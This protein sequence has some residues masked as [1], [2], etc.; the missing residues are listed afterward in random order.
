MQ[1]R[2]ITIIGTSHIAKSSIEQVKTT[3]EVQKPDIVAIELDKGRAHSLMS[4]ERSSVSWH[5]ISRIGLKGYL[6]AKLGHWVEHKLGKVVGVAPGSE[7]K[8]AILS[9]RMAK[10]QLALIDQPIQRT[11][12]RFSKAFSWREKLQLIWDIL[13][14]PFKKK[15][16]RFD[17]RKVPSHKLIDEMLREVEFKYPNIY[18]VLITERN[19]VMARRLY[20]MSALNP[21]RKILAIIGAGHVRGI[22]KLLKQKELTTDVIR[23]TFNVHA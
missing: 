12:A 11:L 17:L 4:D 7:M 3:I 22:L 18:R 21:D 20:A 19:E 10:A 5:S 6:F 13:S 23:Y 14:A 15:R 16:I 2:N 9:A 1:Y 8:Q